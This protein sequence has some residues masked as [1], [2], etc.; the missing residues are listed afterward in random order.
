MTSKRPD[1]L[2]GLLLV[3]LIELLEELGWVECDA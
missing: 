3:S 2:S 1:K